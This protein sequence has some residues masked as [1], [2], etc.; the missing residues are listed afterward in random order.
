MFITQ[1]VTSN[2][3][4]LD[5]ALQRFMAFDRLTN[6]PLYTLFPHEALPDLLAL[7]QKLVTLESIQKTAAEYFKIRVS[8]LLS[9]KRTRSIARPRQ[10][11]M[12]LAKEL[13]NHS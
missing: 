7:H 13:T 11:E 4:D 10:V 9:H 3:R 12:A 5:G 2:L 6:Q 1:R 8:D